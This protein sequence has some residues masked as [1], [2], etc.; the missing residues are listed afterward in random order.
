[1]F[2]EEYL[3]K[4]LPGGVGL[5]FDEWDPAMHLCKPFDPPKDWRRFGMLDYGYVNPLC[6]LMIAISPDG[7]GFV[8]REVYRSRMLDSDQAAL[9]AEA[10]VGDPPE[11]VVAGPDLWNKSGKG[12]KGQ[13]TAETYDEVWRKRGF[14][15]HLK[16]A[17]NDRF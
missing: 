15:T 2:Q 3:A 1:M 8:Y 9:V 14:K 6:F 7:Q 16:M 12:P 11:Y 10:C 13:S 4:F 5:Y 17:A